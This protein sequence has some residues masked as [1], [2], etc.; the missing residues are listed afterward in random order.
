MVY[1]ALGLREMGA[2]EEALVLMQDAV[3][4]ARTFPLMEHGLLFA[5]GGTYQASQQWEEARST[6]EKAETLAERLDLGPFRPPVL[7]RL[8]LHYAVAE[9]WAYAYPFALRA[10][11]VR[12]SFEMILIML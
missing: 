10:F 8:C 5:L 9:A 3:A 4:Q 2:Y 6:L 12:Q 11:A 7:S 1:L